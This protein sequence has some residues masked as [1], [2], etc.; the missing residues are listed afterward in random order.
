MREERY[1]GRSSVGAYKKLAGE[2]RQMWGAFSVQCPE[3]GAPPGFA[4]RKVQ[5]KGQYD[6]HKARR[7]LAYA[8]ALAQALA[9]TD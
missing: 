7:E 4:C 9:A 1:M 8:Q 5:G 2:E 3:C 6:S